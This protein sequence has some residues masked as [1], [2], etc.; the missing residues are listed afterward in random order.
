MPI[1][2]VDEKL[3]AFQHE[4]SDQAGE[5][6]LGHVN[7]A[8]QRHFAADPRL[9]EQGELVTAHARH[10]VVFGHAT[11]QAG[12]HLL[13]HAVA[14]G[15]A[16]GVVDRFEAVEVE[17]HQH[18]PRLLPFGRLQRGVQAVLEQRAVGQVGQGR[19]NRPGGGCAVRW[20][21]AR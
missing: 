8:V 5:D 13:E 21:C 4:R 2:A 15:V 19:R 14:G 9:Q 1:L 10:G 20:P 16:Q 12:S 17:E 18:H 11:E 3:A 7:R 6:L